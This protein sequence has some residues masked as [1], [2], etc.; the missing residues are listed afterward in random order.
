MDSINRIIENGKEVEPVYKKKRGII[1]LRQTDDLILFRGHG[2]EDQ[3]TGVP[4]F[5]GRI[6][7][8]LTLEEGYAAAKNAQLLFLER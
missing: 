4:L 8:D 3:I 7:E 2:P 5:Q 1:L 6:G